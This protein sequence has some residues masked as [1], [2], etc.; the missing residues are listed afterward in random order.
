MNSTVDHIAVLVNDL[1]EA[2]EWYISQLGA[3]ITHKQLNYYRLKLKNVN[4]ALLD[5]SFSTSKPHI[6]VLCEE[7]SDL[8]ENGARISHRDGSTGVYVKDLDGNYLEFIHYGL[9]SQKFIK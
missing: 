6:G 5:S 2:S 9:K 7:M 4:I 8:P 1:K 3:T